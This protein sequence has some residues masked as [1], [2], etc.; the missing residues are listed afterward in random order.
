[1]DD[2]FE[3][4]DHHMRII[5]PKGKKTGRMNMIMRPTLSVVEIPAGED[6]GKYLLAAHGKND[7]G[8]MTVVELRVFE[9]FDEA[10]VVFALVKQGRLKEDDVREYEV[11]E[12]QRL[13]FARKFA[14]E[15]N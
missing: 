10:A 7:V 6:K 1:M 4:D 9:F 15:Q 13:T 8:E 2:T 14:R 5:T 12:K 11:T 3:R